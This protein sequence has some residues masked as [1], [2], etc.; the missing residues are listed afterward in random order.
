[1]HIKIVS[2]AIVFTLAML[3]RPACADDPTTPWRGEAAFHVSYILAGGSSYRGGKAPATGGAAFIPT[4][5]VLYTLPIADLYAAASPIIVTPWSLSATGFVGAVDLG[6][7]WHPD[8]RAWSIGTGGTI[9]PSYLR[10]CNEAWCL[11]QPLVLYGGEI[12]IVGR[13]LETRDG[14]GLSGT[15]SARVL[16]GRPTAWFWPRLTPEEAAINHYSATIGGGLLLR[17]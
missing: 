3:T 16:T 2:I 7:A 12:H 11:K 13:F 1:M 17:F 6:L 15:L 4:A 5:R 8:S 10:F 9:A 14:G